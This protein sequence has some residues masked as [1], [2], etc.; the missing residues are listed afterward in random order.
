MADETQNQ[1]L[2]D[3]SVT[4]WKFEID[5]F[6]R[7][8]LFFWGFIATAVAAYGAAY[9]SGSRDLQL[10]AACFGVVCSF[11]WVL[12]NHSNKYWQD[13]WEEK[14]K[15]AQKDALDGIDWFFSDPGV[16]RN[17]LLGPIHFSV[18]KI[19]LALSYFT[20]LIWIAL[21][22]R[23]APPISCPISDFYISWAM[24]L[25]T[26][27]VSMSMLCICRPTRR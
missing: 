1:R 10:L 5:L 19:A 6:W 16:Q 22:I 8:S 13:F 15:I 25:F 24:L 20:L 21:A 17:A 9:K 26:F 4:T 27:L 14:I 3:Y 7:R 23:S 12:V 2:L 11:S 18:S